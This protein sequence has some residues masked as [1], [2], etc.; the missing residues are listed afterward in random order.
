MSCGARPA[1][2]EVFILLIKNRSW[3]LA[4]QKEVASAGDFQKANIK[5]GS[6]LLTIGTVDIILFLGIEDDA[7]TSDA[8][9]P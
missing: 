9:P 3:L 4:L 7:Y 6:R 5:H 2:A 1:Y 8:R